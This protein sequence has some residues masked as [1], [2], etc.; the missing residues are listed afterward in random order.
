[1]DIAALL[2]TY[3]MVL[4][5]WVSRAGMSARIVRGVTG[6]TKLTR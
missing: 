1:L 4:R 2:S 6:P 5:P 3:L